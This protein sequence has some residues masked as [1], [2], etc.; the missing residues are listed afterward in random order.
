MEDQDLIELAKRELKTICMAE[1]SDIEDGVVIRQPHTYPVYD[2]DYREARDQ[3]RSYVDSLENLQ[4]IGR[5]GLHRYDNQDHAMLSAI[6]AVKNLLGES[7]ELWTINTEKE[8][9]EVVLESK[10]PVPASAPN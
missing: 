10:E 8:Y 4:T 2:G 6:L 5:N 7:H 3:V 1:P 9:H